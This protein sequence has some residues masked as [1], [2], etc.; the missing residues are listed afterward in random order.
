M[1]DLAEPRWPPGLAMMKVSVRGR[2]GCGRRRCERS[3]PVRAPPPRPYPDWP[4]D[5]GPQFPTPETVRE[6]AAVLRSEPKVAALTNRMFWVSVT[7][8]A[9][10]G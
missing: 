4:R 1:E 2:P 6:R 8:T 10:P 7:I 5:A 9:S 3:A